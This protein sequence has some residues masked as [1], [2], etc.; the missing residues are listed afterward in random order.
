MGIERSNSTILNDYK[1]QKNIL[2]VSKNPPV[3]IEK[4]HASS[5]SS[6]IKNSLQIANS[7]LDSRKFEIVEKA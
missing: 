5:N 3:V 4:N 6:T 1:M 7:D 2:S